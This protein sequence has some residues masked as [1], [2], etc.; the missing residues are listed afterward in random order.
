MGKSLG[1]PYELNIIEI[2]NTPNNLLFILIYSY[3]I[4]LVVTIL[5]LLLDNRRPSSSIAWILILIFVPY[6]G[7]I[8]YLIFGKN[9]RRTIRKKDIVLQLFEKKAGKFIL[10]LREK[11]KKVIKDMIATQKS[12]T[13]KQL[14][15]FLNKSSHSV[16]SIQNKITVFHQGKD[17][18]KSL[19]KD[20]KNAKSS[21]HLEYYIWRNDSLCK[22]I[23]DILIEKAKAGVEVRILVDFIGSIFL[24]L[25]KVRRLR[26]AGIFLYPFKKFLSPFKFYALNLRNHRKI[27]VIDGHISYLGGMNM[28]QEYID[29]GTRFQAWNDTHLR[30]VGEASAVV[31]NVFSVDWFN[32]TKEA[33]FKPNYYALDTPEATMTP[34]QISTSG[35][36]SKWSSV[37]QSYFILIT[38]AEKSVYIKTP[39]FIPDSS[40]QMG[41]ITA[42]L[43]GLDVRIMIAGNSDKFIPH[44][45]AF[46]FFKDLLDAGVK[47]YL[48]KAGFL[49]SKTVC[50]DGKICSIGTANMDLRSFD[51]NYELTS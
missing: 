34:I 14:I 27:V 3:Q 11:E 8:F 19:K 21:I 10:P 25:S 20:L 17:K 26:A 36:D 43:K 37:H 28:G 4:Y 7:F 13:R 33:L 35:P 45:A 50:I 9:P 40:I 29:G 15:K 18:F 16:L 48:Y 12:L 23:E 39:Y 32:I 24:S 38:E 31:Q 44:W 49:H 51:I 41:L 22:E 47:I 46:T 42:A 5:F 30:I 1:I 2:M 6:L